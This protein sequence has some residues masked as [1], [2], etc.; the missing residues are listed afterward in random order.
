MSPTALGSTSWAATC[1]IDSVASSGLSAPAVT[2]C[3]SS[4]TSKASASKRRVKNASASSGR[5][6]GVL[7]DRA[8]ALGRAHVDGA[9][10]VDPA[11][12]A[13]QLVGRSALG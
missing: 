3:S 7:A 5:A 12:L 4:C 1:L 2:R 8:L 9:V 10:R 11:P 6:L 13:R